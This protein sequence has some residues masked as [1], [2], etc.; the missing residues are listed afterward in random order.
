MVKKKVTAVTAPSPVEQRILM[1]RG[2]RVLLDADLAELYDVPTK[3]LNEQM[4]RNR[5]RFPAEF[6]FQLT[7]D[8]KAE[9]VANCD[10]LA[11]LKFSPVL[12]YA[13]TE[14]GALMAANVLNSS[15]AVE[16]GVYIVR[17]FVRLSEALLSNKK[18]ASKLDAL[19]N[20]LATHDQAITRLIQAIRQL[21]ALPQ[22][23]KRG[24]DEE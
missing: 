15:R 24:I 19:E 14:Y 4:K 6:M 23:K 12:P 8:E 10:H 21:T 2:Q 18:F 5:A 22:T 11:R 9:V 16:V 20:K 1:L 13:F 17:T 3:R 7:R